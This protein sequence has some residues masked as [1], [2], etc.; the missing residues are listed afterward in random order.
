MKLPTSFGAPTAIAAAL[1][2]L[3]AIV[4]T[5]ELLPGRKAADSARASQPGK[6][7]AVNLSRH[8]DFILP[9]LQQFREIVD[10]PLFVQTRR[11]A[12]VDKS[13]S[14]VAGQP[15]AS[16][17]QISL[18]AVIVS[19]TQRIALFRNTQDKKTIRVEEGKPLQGWLLKEVL[20]ES[21][22]L[23][24]EGQEQKFVLVRKTPDA[25]QLQ[26]LRAAAQARKAQQQ[27][28]A[29][30]AQPTPAAVA[31]GRPHQQPVPNA[32]QNQPGQPPNAPPAQPGVPP[33]VV[34]PPMAPQAGN[35][36]H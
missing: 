15:D 35:L 21:V 22:T 36:W 16:L 31:P 20:A 7:P 32:P 10:R 9:P 28:R 33:A 30:A 12:A 14:A 24:R 11:P 27:A 34:P 23:A 6:K 1:C 17:N 25:A 5:L 2:T 13:A 26:S 19:S 3:L 18:S 29:R 4:L 8:D